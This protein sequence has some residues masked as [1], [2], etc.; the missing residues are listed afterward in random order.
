VEA[1]EWIQTISHQ[2]YFPGPGRWY[3]RRGCTMTYTPPLSPSWEPPATP[4]IESPRGGGPGWH[5]YLIPHAVTRPVCTFC[6]TWPAPPHRWLRWASS[7]NVPDP[8]RGTIR[9]RQFSQTLKV[10]NMCPLLWTSV[11]GS[12]CHLSVVWRCVLNKSFT[13][14]NW[15]QSSRETIQEYGPVETQRRTRHPLSKVI[16]FSSSLSLLFKLDQLY[17]VYSFLITVEYIDVRTN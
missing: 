11:H 10:G 8:L 2:F 3:S 12:S 1:A 9:T 7:I 13:K 5:G 14:G 16:N 4:E 17:I 6:R 15:F